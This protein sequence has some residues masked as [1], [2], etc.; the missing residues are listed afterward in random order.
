MILLNQLCTGGLFF[1]F[2][3]AC[4]PLAYEDCWELTLISVNSGIYYSC[5]VSKTGKLFCSILYFH[6]LTGNTY[7][8]TNTESSY[9]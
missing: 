5:L 9:D 6:I 8:V 4:T 7:S 3:I 2:V 1:H